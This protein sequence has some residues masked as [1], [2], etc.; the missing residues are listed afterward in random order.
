MK[1]LLVII[2]VLT[3][4][5]VIDKAGNFNIAEP[6]K[7]VE[8]DDVYTMLHLADLGLSTEAFRT[9]L[10]GF[11]KLRKDGKLLN[12][13]LLTIID[14]SQPS[15]KKRMYVI[16]LAKKALLFNTYVAHGRNT[17]DEFANRFSNVPGTYQSSLGFY[18]TENMSI[19]SKVGLSLILKGLE[20]G[21][22]D[23]ARER[24][25]IM[26]GADYATEDFI[27]KHGRL[28]RSYGC[29]SLPPDLIKP[30]A[31]TIKNGSLLFIYKPDDN[32]MHKSSV[33][34]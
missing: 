17:G 22:N 30:V 23:K 25:I 27:Q 24:E 10:R 5:P 3:L 19:G 4:L 13:S 14:F 2:L 6:E 34:N 31:E 20:S 18:L 11:E 9:A 1:K 26:H 32:Y 16:D 8:P 12:E 29:P 28:G 21:I 15:T 33:L 7:K